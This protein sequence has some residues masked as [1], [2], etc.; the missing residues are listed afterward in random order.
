MRNLLVLPLL[1]S[2]YPAFAADSPFFDKCSA[3]LTTVEYQEL[4]EKPL[5]SDSYIR[6]LRSP[7]AMV[8]EHAAQILKKIKPNDQ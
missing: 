3:A 6:E 8:A 5:D 4:V 7:N 2:I 1:L